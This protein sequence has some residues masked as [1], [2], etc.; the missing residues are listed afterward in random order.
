[1]NTSLL[2]Q[3]IDRFF[4]YGSFETPIWLIGIEEGG[5][6]SKQNIE[7]R[8]QSWQMSNSDELLDNYEHHKRLKATKYFEKQDGQNIKIQ[9]TWNKLIRLLLAF[10]E[11]TI[12]KDVVRAFQQHRLGRKNSDHCLLEIFPLASPSNN[13]WKYAEWFHENELLQSRE[14]Y[15]G[16]VGS[17][18]LETLKHKISQYKPQVVV[19]YSTKM[20]KYW[21]VLIDHAATESFSMG[22]YAAH[23][24]VK[25]GTLYV[26][27]PHPIRMRR[28]EYWHILGDEI[29]NRVKIL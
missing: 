6:G 27:C 7:D 4:G 15:Q 2:Q 20:K 28:N 26:L 19:C 10:N 12:S 5:G 25:E 1:M 14:K 23:F 22:I 16:E 3:Y 18:R 24:V 29:R 21:D 13:E 9:P 11:E 17:Q 8:I